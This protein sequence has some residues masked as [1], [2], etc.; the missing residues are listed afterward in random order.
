MHSG[1]PSLTSYSIVCIFYFRKDVIK[2]GSVCWSLVKTKGEISFCIFKY[3]K[4]YNCIKYLVSLPLNTLFHYLFST[5]AVFFRFV[6]IL[7]YFS[8]FII[9]TIILIFQSSQC[10]LFHLYF[11]STICAFIVFNF[12]FRSSRRNVVIESHNISLTCFAH[13]FICSITLYF[14]CLQESPFWR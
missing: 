7:F 13:N 14:F 1:K 2:K 9:P 4:S 11:Y 6:F 3:F 12:I 8:C 10:Y 5:G